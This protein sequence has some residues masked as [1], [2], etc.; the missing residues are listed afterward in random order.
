MRADFLNRFSPQF[1]QLKVSPVNIHGKAL[2]I[3]PYQGKSLECTVAKWVSSWGPGSSV[4]D[5]GLLD[6]Q[7]LVENALGQKRTWSVNCW[8]VLSCSEQ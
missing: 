7:K 1:E 3:A 4:E 8:S 2:D 6:Y 5:L